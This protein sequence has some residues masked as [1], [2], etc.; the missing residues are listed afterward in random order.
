MPNLAQWLLVGL[1]VLGLLCGMLFVG[2]GLE[3]LL[4]RDD[5]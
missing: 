5:P 3:Q 2:W 4:G 1:T